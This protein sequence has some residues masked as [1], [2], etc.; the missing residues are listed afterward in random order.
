MR[1]RRWL[2][3]DLQPIPPAPGCPAVSK[4]QYLE[5]SLTALSSNMCAGETAEHLGAAVSISSR[6]AAASLKQRAQEAKAC[7]QEAGRGLLQAPEVTAL[8]LLPS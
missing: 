6:E 4:H 5:A 8:L 2:D 3:I 7:L 1:L